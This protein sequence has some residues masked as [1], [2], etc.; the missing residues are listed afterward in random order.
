MVGTRWTFLMMM[1]VALVGCAAPRTPPAVPGLPLMRSFDMV[2][3][4]AVTIVN[5]TARTACD[6]YLAPTRSEEWGN[7]WLEARQTLRPGRELHVVAPRA[8]SW[9]IRI[10]DCGE[11]TFAQRRR[12]VLREGQIA[13]LSIRDLAAPIAAIADRVRLARATFRRP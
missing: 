12:V 13:R 7:D 10:Q 6:V 5:D 2:T 11:T 1:T 3:P 4:V 8:G 9:D